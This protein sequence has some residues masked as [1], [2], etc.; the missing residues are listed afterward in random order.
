MTEQVVAVP[1]VV[2]A[3]VPEQAPHTSTNTAV[4]STTIHV[5]LNRAD[6]E[7]GGVHNINISL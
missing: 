4:P 6:I 5:E 2:T 3:I 7:A 1:E